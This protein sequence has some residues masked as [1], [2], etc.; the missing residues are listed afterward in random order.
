[1]KINTFN[2]ARKRLKKAISYMEIS[3]DV[4]EQLKYPKM[5]LSAS[6][7]VR[8][9]DGS[10]KAFLAYRVQYDDTRG[11]TKG[12]IR[13]HPDVDLNEVTSLAFWMTF[14]TA[15]TNL[16]FGGAKG[17]VCVNPKQLSP[18]ELERLSRAYIDAFYHNLGPERDIP[19]PDMYTNAMIM[20]WM[21]N[22]YSKIK[23]EYTPSSIT[24]K[25]LALGGSK[26]RIDA[27]GRGG[28]YVLNTLASQLNIVPQKTTVA[29]QGFGNVATH[30]S[31]LMHE[32][33]YKIIAVSDSGGGIYTSEGI[34]PVSLLRFKQE[35]GCVQGAPVVG[36]QKLI[37]NAELLT[38]PVDILIPAAIEN[39]ITNINAPNIQARIIIEMANGPITEAADDILIDKGITVIPDILAN[40]GG[41]T[42]SYFEWVQNKA[43]MYWDTLEVYDRLKNIMEKETLRIWDIKTAKQ[44]EMRTAAY[45]Y[46]LT[47]IA[48]AIEAGGTKDYFSNHINEK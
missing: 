15:I 34:D 13:Y 35:K 30:M 19:A 2:E 25:P 16:P 43:G 36:E 7:N 10:L 1:M 11:P 22:Q 47:R 12:G 41:V 26:G 17:G 48:D 46:A 9:D 37:S 20:G 32:N 38:L 21:A 27:T 6:L 39:V 29:I 45:I 4:E 40:A 23:G 8:M 5:A 42:V 18:A 44:C 28:F 24:G 3:S 31:R 14:K 33:G